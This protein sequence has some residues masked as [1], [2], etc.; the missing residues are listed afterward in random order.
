MKRY[1]KLEIIAALAVLLAIIGVIAYLLWPKTDSKTRQDTTDE[2][3]SKQEESFQTEGSKAIS[4]P[5]ESAKSRVTKKP[6]GIYITPQN[7]P[8]QPERFT[9]YHTGTDFEIM[10]DEADK[11]VLVFAL[12]TG[13]IRIKEVISGYGGVVVQDCIIGDSQVTV[14]YGHLDI[15]NTPDVGREVKS[16][17]RLGVLAPQE[18][19]LSGGERKHLHLGIHR[20]ANVDFRGYVQNESELN[21][22][23]DAKKYL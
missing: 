21:S 2:E 9:G 20:G 14:L 19:E 3:R 22:W 8:V 11:D 13:K 1:F 7:S 12:C 23:I 15:R 10:P 16:G 17:E 5:I 6:F 18:S 4:E